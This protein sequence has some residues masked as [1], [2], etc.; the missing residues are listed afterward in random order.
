M[1]KLSWRGSVYEGRIRWRATL[2]GL[3]AAAIAGGCTTSSTAA[4]KP[5]APLPGK[6]A[7]IFRVNLWDFTVLDDSTLIVY[8]P[9]RHDAY[10]VKLFAPITALTFRQTIGFESLGTTTQLC[11][12]DYVITRG[13]IPERMPIDS[14]RAISPAEVKQLI[15]ASK[16]PRDGNGNG[17]GNGSGSAQPGGSPP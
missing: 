5:A 14:L 17:P 6:E 7:C 13:D 12:G 16:N 10:L 8:G 1:S 2:I 3:A 9:S 4:G 11:R 15:A